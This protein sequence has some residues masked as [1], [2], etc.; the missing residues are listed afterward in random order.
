MRI[1][2]D[3][4]ALLPTP[5]GVDVY[6]R[7]LLI[8]L[9][10]IDRTND[11]RIF[12]NYEDR[13][14]FDNAL[15][16]NFRIVARCLRPRAVRLLFQQAWLPAAVRT[17]DLLHSP[18]F[19]MPAWRGRQKHVLSVHDMTFFLLPHVHTRLRRSR[20]FRQAIVASIE[21]ANR[22]LAPS[23]VTKADILRF[24]PR[25][26]PDRVRVIPYGVAEDFHPSQAAAPGLFTL[27]QT[28]AG[29]AAALNAIDGSINTAVNPVRIGDYVSLYATGEGQTT[30]AGIDGRI[31]SGPMLPQPN[32][33]VS[34]TIGGL[35]AVVQY[36]GAVPNEVAGLMQVNVRIPSGVQT[37][38][39]VPVILEVGNTSTVAGA[40]WIAV[41]GY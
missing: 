12:T 13:R 14:A 38:G 11:Y 6:L 16:P 30:P 24:L 18:S 32:F 19:L 25:L 15:P 41:T 27:N 4:T 23:A 36:A 9:G 31:A 2:I 29:Q 1:A 17:C 39:Y 8:H 33:Q 28:G 21:R 37:G 22:V 3:L 35:P 10:R 20:V 5:T 40:V 7:E 26:D 34:A